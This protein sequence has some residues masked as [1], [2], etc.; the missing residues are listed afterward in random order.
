MPETPRPAAAGQSKTYYLWTELQLSRA[1]EGSSSPLGRRCSAKCAGHAGSGW[2][3][4]LAGLTRGAS[5]AQPQR[6][7]PG[8][9]G[10]RRLWSPTICETPSCPC[11]CTGRFKVPSSLAVST[12]LCLGCKTL[13]KVLNCHCKQGHICTAEPLLDMSPVVVLTHLGSAELCLEWLQHIHTGACSVALIVNRQC[14][15]A[16][17]IGLQHQANPV[18]TSGHALCRCSLVCTGRHV[19]QAV[20]AA[21]LQLHVG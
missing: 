16:S 1:K 11:R 15:P 9:G 19:V 7:L 6:W 21:R 8:S 2:S 17:H 14:V 12:C 18:T 3:P 20:E 5:A 4:C 13:C 10:P